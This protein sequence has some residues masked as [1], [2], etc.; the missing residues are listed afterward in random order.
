MRRLMPAILVVA[1]CFGY[2]VEEAEEIALKLYSDA[3]FPVLLGYHGE[4]FSELSLAESYMPKN[5]EITRMMAEVSAKIRRC[6]EALNY[7]RKMISL[8]KDGV[9]QNSTAEVLAQCGQCRQAEIALMKSANSG[10]ARPET[11]LKTAH[12]YTIKGENDEALKVLKYGTSIFPTNSEIL[13]LLGE[14]MISLGKRNEGINFIK[15]AMSYDESPGYNYLTTL[16][17]AYSTLGDTDSELIVIGRYV[18]IFPKHNKIFGLYL[19][20]LANLGKIEELK[21]ALNLYLRFNKTN[22]DVDIM[23]NLALILNRSG[24]TKLAIE[25]LKMTIDLDTIGNCWLVM[26]ECYNALYCPES[27]LYACKN[28]L[29]K[30]QDAVAWIT[31]A[32]AYSELGET[33][34]SLTALFNALDTDPENE[35][36]MLDAA[37]LLFYHKMYHFAG[38]LAE[39]YSRRVGPSTTKGIFLLGNI[40][41]HAGFRAECVSAMR[42]CIKS[43]TSATVLNF[44]GYILADDKAK[45]NEAK[46]L[47]T[48]AL[49]QSPDE[50]AII[51]SWGWYLFRIEKTKEALHWVRKA[52]ARYDRDP[53]VRL[54]LGDIHFALGEIDSALFYWRKSWELDPDNAAIKK[55]INEVLKSGGEKN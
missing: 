37:N 52:H 35:E 49:R 10:D 29:L 38:I 45:L 54:H 8:C 28:R 20:R 14:V 3:L 23:N 16:A 9:C 50:P 4:G 30:K 5:Y 55:R 24:E 51:D 18:R 41:E 39:E 22:V 33:E 19:R 53:E 11:F 1:F 34:S 12:C 6:D 2:V 43:D 36:I 27:V 48:R 7:A 31:L 40:K 32:F 26:A 21:K 46:S 13:S 42:F 25:L 47:L 15:L 17:D 44:L